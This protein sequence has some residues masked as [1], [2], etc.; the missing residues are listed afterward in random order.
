MS[1]PSTLLTDVCIVVVVCSLDDSFSLLS[2]PFDARHVGHSGVR[3]GP[4][5]GS[6]LLVH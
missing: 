2:L 4:V 1:D 3:V 6:K 5:G